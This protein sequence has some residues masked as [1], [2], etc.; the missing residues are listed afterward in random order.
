MSFEARTY[1]QRKI[2]GSSHLS[3][4]QKAKLEFWCINND[5]NLQKLIQQFFIPVRDIKHHLQF[6]PILLWLQESLHLWTQ[7]KKKRYHGYKED[8]WLCTNHEKVA[9]L[10]SEIQHPPQSKPWLR[11]WQVNLHLNIQ[12]PNKLVHQIFEHVK[13]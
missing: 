9:N 12:T 3:I 5:L 11:L 10:Q 6:H 13:W 8:L 2:Q 7:L 1:I 4:I